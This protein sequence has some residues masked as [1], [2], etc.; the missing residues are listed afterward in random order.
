VVSDTLPDGLTLVSSTPQPASAAGKWQWSLGDLQG[1]EA[2]TIDMRVRADRPGTI[3]HCASVTTAEKLSAQ[4]CIA[5]TILAPSLRVTTTGPPQAQV[6]DDV[7]FQV[8]VTNTGSSPL[9]GLVIVD[10][11]DAGLQHAS[12]PN[13]T[14]RVIERTL[15]DLAAGQTRNIDV[16]LR[17][18]Q[19]GQQCNAVEVQGTAGILGSA[20]AC[21]TAVEL[22]GAT[23]AGQPKLS[24]AKNG[25][26]QQVE[27]GTATFEIT[28]TNTGQA[29]ATNLTVTDHLDAALE[30]TM[31]TKTA[32]YDGAGDLFWQVARLDVGKT[33]RFK[34]E[35]KCLEPAAKACNRVTVTSD[36]GARETA[37]F[38]LQ[39]TP[40]TTSSRPAATAIAGLQP[41]IADQGDPVTVG[42]QTTYRISV[43]NNGS[44]PEELVVVSVT[45]PDSLTPVAAGI[46]GP[47]PGKA[48]GKTVQF[49]PVA[50][51]APGKTLSFTVAARADAGGDGV[52]R[53]EVTSKSQTTPVTT[54]ATTTVIE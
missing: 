43:A 46:K 34:L 4:D 32:A 3:N 35:C 26:Q 6:G 49:A 30:A 25:T 41:S 21:L 2:R 20:K 14:T 1:G 17:V 37:E 29:A 31:A 15:G 11:Y 36:E 33:I 45:L 39:I 13:A 52:A 19:A 12:Q 47:T 7:P 44:A 22:G 9:T 38:C 40:A 42:K 51:L 24:I 50:T 48:T 5:T 18:V 27:G 8:Q 54:E 53:V 16:T 28:I 23:A 10:R